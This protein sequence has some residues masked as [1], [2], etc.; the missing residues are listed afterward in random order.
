MSEFPATLDDALR[1]LADMHT[2]DDNRVGFTVSPS[3]LRFGPWSQT[4]YL[5]A[6]GIIRQHLHMQTEPAPPTPDTPPSE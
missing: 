2:R 1:V 5:A 6:F 4:Q 3:M